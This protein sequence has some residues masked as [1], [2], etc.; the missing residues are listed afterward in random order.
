[1]TVPVAGRGGQPPGETLGL[2]DAKRDVRASE[3]CCERDVRE[4][5]GRVQEA[6]SDGDKAR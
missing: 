1:M 2:P 3:I 6:D 4:A 5:A